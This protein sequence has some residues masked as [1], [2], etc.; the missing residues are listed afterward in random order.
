M[1][2][3]VSGF[4]YSINGTASS[5]ADATPTPQQVLVN[6]GFEPAEDYALI[7]VEPH[8]TRVL[9]ADDVLSSTGGP[10]ELYAFEGGQVFCVTVNQHSVWWGNDVIDIGLLR[11]IT[12]VAEGDDLVYLNVEG[13]NRVLPGQ[14]NFKLGEP[15]MEHLKTHARSHLHVEYHYFVGSEKFTTFS[16]ELTGAQIIAQISNWIPENS[17]VLESEGSGPD[18]VIRATTVVSFKNRHGFAHFSIVPPATFGA[19]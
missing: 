9:S 17:L 15:G 18:E 8:G 5:L 3:Q 14:G 2:G 1:V 4:S 11:R 19:A 10:V 13:S 7:V 16:E 12:H 6:A